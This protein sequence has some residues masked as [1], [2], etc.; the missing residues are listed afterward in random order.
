MPRFVLACAVVSSLG[1]CRFDA[2]YTGAHFTCT[3][4]V[5]PSGLACVA[6]VC[7]APG[8]AASADARA[9]DARPAALTCADP[10][11]LPAGGGSASGTTATRADA[12]SATCNALVMN[13]PDAVYAVDAALGQHVAISIAGSYPVRAYLLTPCLPAP[14]QPTCIGN[15]FASAGS[16]VT[17]TAAVAGRQYV[18]VD[19]ENAALA[20]TYDLAVTVSN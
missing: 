6:K 9:I 2:D 3:D 17:I 15:A 7:V 20:G 14:Q 13:G 4:G 1:A 16:P 12:M 10:G 5:C 8:D 19:G 18:V 11:V